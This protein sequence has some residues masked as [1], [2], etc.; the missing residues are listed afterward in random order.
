M[1]KQESL[2][3]FLNDKVKKPAKP[4]ITGPDDNVCISCEG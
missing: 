2:D 1:K 4:R 3:D